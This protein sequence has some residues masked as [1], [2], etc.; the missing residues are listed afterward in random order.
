M[1]ADSAVAGQLVE[2]ALLRCDHGPRFVT[3]AIERVELAESRPV[4]PPRRHG[5]MRQRRLERDVHT[6]AGA[7]G[8][9]KEAGRAVGHDSPFQG[10]GGFDVKP[11]RHRCAARTPPTSTRTGGSSGTAD[12]GVETCEVR[13]VVTANGVT[14]EL[15]R[16]DWDISTATRSRPSTWP[17][18]RDGERL[19]PAPQPRGLRHRRRRRHPRRPDYPRE[20]SPTGDQVDVFHLS[21]AR[22][23]LLGVPPWIWH[24][25]QN[26]DGPVVV[27]EP[28]RSAPTTTRI[29]MSGAS[30]TH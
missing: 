9:V 28:L 6:R 1:T 8:Y 22:P 3:E 27:R 7:P 11:R 5:P 23:T 21:P 25:V 10:Y 18:R 19:A 24:G 13:N 4:H 16:P 12:Q 17:A 20:D 29:P 15:F 30:P 2:F 26:L 14:T